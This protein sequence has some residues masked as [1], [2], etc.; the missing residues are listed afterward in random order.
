M[1]QKCDFFIKLFVFYKHMHYF[2][3][4]EVSKKGQN[5][6]ITHVRDGILVIIIMYVYI[7]LLIN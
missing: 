6:T 4:L 2:C 7:L 5:Y 3:K 1:V